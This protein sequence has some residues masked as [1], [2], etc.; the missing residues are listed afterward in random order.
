M[1]SNQ[2][3][4]K[5]VCVYQDE[6]TGASPI[7][8]S[9]IGRN[10]KIKKSSDYFMKSGIVIDLQLNEKNE[11]LKIQLGPDICID[12][13]TMR[14][15]LE[16]GPLGLF[17]VHCLQ[18]N[19]NFS[20][21]EGGRLSFGFL[22]KIFIKESFAFAAK[23]ILSNLFKMELNKTFTTEKNLSKAC[24]KHYGSKHWGNFDIVV[25]KTA[26]GAWAVYKDSSEKSV[27]RIV[28]RF[29]VNSAGVALGIEEMYCV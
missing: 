20:A 27:E 12:L 17:P 9:I 1:N 18:L 28:A 14:E 21:Q 5:S 4:S 15:G 10:L 24:L 26:S 2:V 6:A 8:L 19:E 23:R 16:I 11:I 3:I 7:P 29:N 25:K 22:K 13:Q